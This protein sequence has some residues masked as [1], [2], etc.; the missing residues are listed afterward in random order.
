MLNCQILCVGKLKERFFTE[1]S[2]EYEKRLSRY[3]RLSIIEVSDEKAP[4][5]LSA[6]QIEQVKEAEG[7]RLIARL[8]QDAHA[9][10]LALD[11]KTF[12]SPAWSNW[13]SGH[14]NQGVSKLAFIIGGSNGLS[15]AVLKR[16][17]ERVSFSEFTFSHQLMRIILLEQIYRSMKIMSGESY[18]K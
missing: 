13:F 7:E 1:A 10:A 9:V 2:K 16:C 15:E 3:I 11:G 12:S 5:N 14:M 6:A 17:K 8:P 18:H 4:P